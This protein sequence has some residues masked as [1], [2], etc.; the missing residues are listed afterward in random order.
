MPTS[1]CYA[2]PN[3]CQRVVLFNEKQVHGESLNAINRVLNRFLDLKKI[4]SKNSMSCGK[5]QL[6]LSSFD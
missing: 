1:G 2:Q 4:S 5:M 3:V 6:I